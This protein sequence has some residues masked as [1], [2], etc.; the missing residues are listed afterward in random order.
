[1]HTFFDTLL[2]CFV[3]NPTCYKKMGYF[4]LNTKLVSLSHF[5][6]NAVACDRE[7]SH[8]SLVVMVVFIMHIRKIVASVIF[9]LFPSFCTYVRVIAEGMVSPFQLLQREVLIV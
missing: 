9:P 7:L 8:N 6:T 2:N 4:L 3:Q 1:M 5:H